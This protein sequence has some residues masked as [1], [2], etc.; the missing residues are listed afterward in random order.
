M[1]EIEKL[2]LEVYPE[3]WISIGDE[4]EWD[5]NKQYRDAW[6][7]GYKKALNIYGFLI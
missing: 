3:N 6:I 4:P 5:V 2:A 7:E 1:K